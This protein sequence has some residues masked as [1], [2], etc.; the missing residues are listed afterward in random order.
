MTVDGDADG[1]VDDIV[2]QG[3]L[4]YGELPLTEPFDA[5]IVDPRLLQ[6]C[7]KTLISLSLL[8]QVGSVQH[9]VPSEAVI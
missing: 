4:L 5:D 7:L 8:I 1:D 2:R 3:A 6:V 9:L